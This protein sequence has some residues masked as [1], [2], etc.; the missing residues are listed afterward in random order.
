MSQFKDVNSILVIKLRHIGDVLL[1]VPVFR[2]LRET[3]PGARISALVNSGTEEAL[4]GSPYINEIMVFDGAIKNLS[5]AR[6]YQREIKFLKGIRTRDFDMT[7]DLTGG[8]RASIISASSGA[9]YKL[10]WKPGKGL[11]W[12]KYIYTHMI[13]PR[14]GRHMVLQNLEVV[15]AFGIK[16]GDLSVDFRIHAR[17][18]DYAGDILGKRP[19]DALVH[20]HPTSRWLFKCW[21]DKYMADVINW[22]IEQG[23]KVVVTSSADKKEFE[24]AKKILSLCPALTAARSPRLIDLCGK[25]TLGQLAAVSGESD[26]FLGVDSAPM[27]IAAAVATPVIALFGPSG[28]FNWGPWDNSA[29][30]ENA[31][32]NRNGLQI[33]GAHT[34]VQ[35]EWECVPCGEDG[36]QRSKRSRCLEDITPEEIRILLQRYLP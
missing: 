8:D 16:T 17:D 24:K 21:D 25:T 18:M 12:K 11:E 19:G 26:F 23:I 36:C 10:G 9:K 3:F 15:N 22:L 13:E 5:G 6:R 32:R 33:C 28:A 14:P 1:T 30:P 35:R 4:S 29:D 31:Y 34:V 2:A 27:H 7:V 20:I